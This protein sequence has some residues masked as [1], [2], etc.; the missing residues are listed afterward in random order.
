MKHPKLAVL[1]QWLNDIM[2]P[3]EQKIF[4]YILVFFL[5]GMVLYYSG[6]SAVYASK[7]ETPSQIPEQTVLPDTV[8]KIDIRTASPEQ[9]DLLPGIGPKKAQAILD[10]R[11][12][13]QFESP[14]ELLNVKGIGNKTL[15]NL[16]PMLLG[17]GTDRAG[18]SDKTGIPKAVSPQTIPPGK[19]SPTVKDTNSIVNL[20]TASLT[21]LMALSGIGEKKAQAILEYRKQVGGFK[22]IEQ[23]TEVKGIGVK[24]LEKNRY[25]MKI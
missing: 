18:V 10:Y 3:D 11:N 12:K 20:N 21:E 25:R 23:I 16:R 5:L 7:K 6:F 8:I 24:T 4:G 13:K 15:E 14:E 2:T 17:F 9:L 22:N 1:K 19:T